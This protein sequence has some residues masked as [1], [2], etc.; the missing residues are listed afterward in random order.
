MSAELSIEHLRKVFP[1]HGVPVLR[2]VAAHDGA[3]ERGLLLAPSSHA[4]A[5]RQWRGG[6][7]LHGASRTR[8]T[9][10]RRRSTSWAYPAHETT[11]SE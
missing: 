9:R 4:A 6:G 11:G 5:R 10:A 2:R 3:P 7:Q 1:T 8:D